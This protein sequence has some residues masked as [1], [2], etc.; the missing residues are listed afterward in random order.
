MSYK[1]WL[2]I[3]VF[4]FGTGVVFGLA[5]PAN[6]SLPS[7][8]ITVFEEQS[9]SILALPRPLIAL[10]IFLKNTLALL[11][12]FALS[13]IFCLVPVL[14]LIINGWMIAFVS[15]MVIQEESLGFLLAGLL[16]HGIFELPALILAQSA[17]LSFGAVVILAL[18]NKRRRNLL[19]PSLKQNLRYLAAALVLLLPAAIIET[20][21]T[22]LFLA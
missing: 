3:A 9:A 15:T 17:A 14:A 19:L 5:T 21:I 2:F 6:N 18:F 8:Y 1:R 11:I 13:P 4:L 10:F 12:S 22:P 20:Y 16:P 7:E